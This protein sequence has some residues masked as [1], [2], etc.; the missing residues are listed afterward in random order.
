MPFTIEKIK[1]ADIE[2][3]VADADELRRKRLQM[4]GGFF[5]KGVEFDWVIDREKD[6]YLLNA[7]AVESR[8]EFL[9]FYF[10]YDSFLHE[11][12]ID[13]NNRKRPAIFDTPSNLSL[14]FK[15]KLAEAFAL[16]QSSL[17]E[18]WYCLNLENAGEEKS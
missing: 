6:I 16:Y 12:K 13:I 11:F 4:R 7:P 8:S 5:V 9:H 15:N 1:L 2:K 10:H 14:D 18:Q 17:G 3:I